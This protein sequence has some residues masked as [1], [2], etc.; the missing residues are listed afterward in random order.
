MVTPSLRCASITARRGARAA[1]LCALVA[2]GCGGQHGLI[3][4]GLSLREVGTVPDPPGAGGRDVGCSIGFAGHSVWIFGDTFFADASADGYHWRASTWSWTD[5][6]DA[7]DGLDGWHH[8]LGAD[9]KP[10]ALLPHTAEEQAFDDA[11][12]GDSCP[13]GSSCGARHTAWPASAVALPTGGALVLYQEEDT[14]GNSF[15]SHGFSIARWATPDAPA[16]R[17]ALAPGT[18]DP[19]VLFP[20]GELQL[21]AAAAIDPEGAFLYAYSCPG[22]SLSSPCTVGRAPV[23][24]ALDR[25]CWTFFDG[26]WWSADFH[27][28]RSVLDGAPIMSVHHSA[29]L[30]AWVAYHMGPLDGH[31][32]MQ[33]A[34]RPE[35]PWSDPLDFGEGETP[36]GDGF[37]YGLVAHPELAR[38]GG[39]I[40]VLSY[41]SPGHFLDGVVHLLEV[42]Y[43]TP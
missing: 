11:H 38:D 13:A 41:F 27:A 1:I 18:A 5:D 14:S 33:T 23:D 24:A 12:N 21:D 3:A 4:R 39:R 25:A 17:P 28:A 42:T 34:P 10:L 16:E 30:G 40:E 15:S 37:D 32:R 35:G 19:T 8:G 2:G 36:A 26:Q 6:R 20:D 9:G 29:F 22:G 7:S 31:L 43:P